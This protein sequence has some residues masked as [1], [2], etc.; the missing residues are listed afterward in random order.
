VVNEHGKLLNIQ[1]TPG[2]TDDRKPLVDWLKGLFGKVFA[3][4]GYVSKALA[5]ELRETWGIEFFAKPRRNM[6]NHLLRLN[7]KLLARKRAIVET[8]IDQLKNICGLI[9]YCY[10][11]KKPAIHPEWI[12]PQ[13]A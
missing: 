11:P 1:I 7:N 9:A 12:L 13:S 3:D 4:R 6:K 10:Q 5:T 2:N 8:V